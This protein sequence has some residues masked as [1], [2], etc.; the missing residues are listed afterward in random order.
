[1]F[2]AK[3]LMLD[4]RPFLKLSLYVVSNIQSKIPTHA[5]LKG[6][7]AFVTSGAGII[8]SQEVKCDL[9]QMSFSGGVGS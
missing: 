2:Q 3:L 9:I 7:V 1:V 8:Y 4:G 6:D 5:K